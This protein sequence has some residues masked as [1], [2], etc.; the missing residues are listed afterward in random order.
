MP[1]LLP[2]LGW[3]AV[4][5]LGAAAF[6]VLALHR[7]ESISAAWILVAALCTWAV[8][9]RFYS[10]IIAQR[11]FAL[12]DARASPAVRLSDGHDY[13]PTNPWVVFGHHFAAIAGAG[14]LVGPILA[15]Q[16]GYLPGTIWII[17]G[18]VLAGAVQDLV[19]LCG[20]LRLDGRSL[21]ELAREHLGPFAGWTT[22]F[23]ITAILAILIAV[24]AMVVVNAMSESPWSTVTVGL[25]LPI[26]MLMGVW[27]RLIRPGRVLEA[28]AIGVALLFG[29]LWAGWAVHHLPH[30]SA[31]RQALTFG[32]ELRHLPLLGEVT[33]REVMAWI[34]IAYGFC[35]AV[36]P[37]WLLLAPRDYLSAFVKIGTV[38]LLALGIFI[39]LPDI[40]MPAVV[41]HDPARAIAGAIGAGDGPVLPGTLMPFAFITIACGAI[42]GFHALIA[43]GTTPKLIARESQA[44]AIGYGGMLTESFVAILA[45]I[46]AC[47][48]TP[49]VYFA[50]NAP[51]GTI[52]READAA[53]GII[54]AWGFA[55]GGEELR[56]LARDIGEESVLSRTGGAP[57]LAVGMALIFDRATSFIGDLKAFWYHF[58]IMFE[59]LFILTTVDAGTRVGRFV[60]QDIIRPAWPALADGTRTW[61]VM[62]TSLAVVSMWGWFLISGVRDPLGGIYVLWPLFGI[63]NQLLAAVALSV[64]TVIIVRQGKARWAWITILPLLWLGGVT[65]AAGWQKLTH[66]SPKVSFVAQ[67]RAKDAEA[68]GLEARIAELATDDQQLPALRKKAAAARQVAFN[69]R[70]DAWLCAIFMLVIVVVALDAARACLRHLRQA[71][72]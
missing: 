56:Q 22:L 2:I 51:A 42:S 41:S 23:A 34:L 54:T 21:G 5:A 6:A 63:S 35:A 15:A 62:A 44:R 17:V 9:Y 59:A 72:A 24:L 65:E 55:V 36:L 64:G 25:T 53:A 8:G 70:V 30:D 12:D 29:A 69:N 1:R 18:V 37:V 38:F 50:M 10:R 13:V 43:S 48:L 31:W 58:A 28:S 71:R 60:L 46:A 11:I 16:F 68:A 14:P 32:R 26:A 47:A 66:E 61:A 20:S 19:I 27:M 39:V 67:A 49:G 7:G 40:R 45:L 33:G 3:S 52:G 57:T 4:A